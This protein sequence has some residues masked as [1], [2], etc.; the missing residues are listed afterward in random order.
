MIASTIVPQRTTAET[1]FELATPESVGFAADLPKRFEI[2]LASGRLQNVHGLVAAAI[3]P[4]RFEPSP[5]F[6]RPLQ[7]QFW[8]AWD[9][10]CGKYRPRATY[11]QSG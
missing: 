5:A 11:V 10:P 2:L 8:N 7:I 3:S 4:A 1:A 6:T 9:E